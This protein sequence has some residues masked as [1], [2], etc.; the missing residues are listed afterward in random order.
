MT[1]VYNFNAGP[2]ILPRPVLEQVQAEMLDY[3]GRGMSIME[4]SH[5]SKEYEAI[6]TEAEALLKRLLG[7]GDE[8]RVLFMQGGASS[9]FPLVPMNFL[10]QGKAADYVLT[11]AWSE[12]AF[13]EAQKLGSPRIAGSTREENYRRVLRP[14]ELELSD[15][16]A[17]VHLTSNETIHGVQWHQFPDT[18]DRRVVIDMSSDILSRPLD[19]RKFALIYAGAQKNLGPSGVTIVVIRQDWMEQAP[20]SL[21]TMFRYATFAK[22]NSL[23]NTP[24]VFAVYVVNLVLRWIE[25]QGGLD[26]MERLNQQKAEAIYSAIDGSEGF[27]RG[28]AKPDSRSLMNITFR[29]PN[30]SLEKDFV[31]AATAAGLVGL[32]G[33]RSVGG[34]RA[35][36][37]NAMS[38]EGARTLAAFMYDFADKNA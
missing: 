33:H 14:D 35:S 28:H 29:L 20:K 31:G 36:L 25:N 23:Y 1:N 7:I 19:A 6:N 21:P 18:G 15:A 9:Q 27:Y 3:Q 12:K 37:Y 4:M 5:R 16:P 32:A 34:I 22:N 2:A 13:E 17:Y 10:P 8:Y 26:A 24:P 30:E 11:G 38:L